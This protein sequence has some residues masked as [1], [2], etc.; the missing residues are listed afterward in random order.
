MSSHREL[1]TSRAV[2]VFGLV[3]LLACIGWA[4]LV[5]DVR[6]D[7]CQVQPPPPNAQYLHC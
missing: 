3:V 6:P 7:A 1:R 4:I 5:Q 2:V